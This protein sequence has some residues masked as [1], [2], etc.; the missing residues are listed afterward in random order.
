MTHRQATSSS[1]VS[2]GGALCGFILLLALTLALPA[3]ADGVDEEQPD[4]PALQVVVDA[5][6]LGLNF[7]NN[8]SGNTS[9]TEPP[10]IPAS[11]PGLKEPVVKAPPAPQTV[12]LLITWSSLANHRARGVAQAFGQP[13]DLRMD[14]LA[15]LAQQGVAFSMGTSLEKM[16]LIEA[17]HAWDGS[18]A[19]EH[20]TQAQAEQNIFYH[21]LIMNAVTKA[22]LN[23]HLPGESHP[24][25]QELIQEVR[26]NNQGAVH[27]EEERLVA[28]FAVVVLF[29]QGMDNL[30]RSLPKPYRVEL[31]KKNGV[32]FRD[33]PF[34]AVA[35]AL[36]NLFP[37]GIMI[38]DAERSVF[39]LDHT[40]EVQARFKK[41]RTYFR[42][43]DRPVQ[44]A[45]SRLGSSF[46]DLEQVRDAYL[47]SII[48]DYGYV[49]GKQVAL[50]LGYGSGKARNVAMQIHFARHQ[51][52]SQDY[53]LPFCGEWLGTLAKDASIPVEVQ[54]AAYGEPLTADEQAKVPEL[55]T[56]MAALQ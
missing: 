36:H 4:S 45:K 3:Q 5:M 38:K 48:I 12:D 44:M 23:Q 20:L 22:D 37:S 51:Q 10:A 14:H 34:M 47:Q 49:A 15:G 17:L 13:I 19:Q 54:K 16:A 31:A 27:P 18:F 40:A 25:V 11:D 1:S 52:C 26:T 29:Y 2:V 39:R 56:M 7:L 28:Q 53:S 6:A 21:G 50:E 9:P 35:K 32:G 42:L 24:F 30:W 46:S 41:L 55:A 33:V 43:M 8:P